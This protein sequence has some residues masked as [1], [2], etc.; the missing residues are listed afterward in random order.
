MSD[1]L[2]SSELKQAEDKLRTANRDFARTHPGEPAARQPVHTVY[3][4]AQLFKADTVRK[5][6]DVALSSLR[7]YAPS[8]EL[9][10]EVLDLDDDVAA[11]VHKRIV[12]KLLREP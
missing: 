9:L 3:G 6:G 10:A 8:A 4:G 12:E 2:V 7:D 11:G 1:H 5:I